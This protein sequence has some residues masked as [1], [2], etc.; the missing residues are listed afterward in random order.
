MSPTSKSLADTSLLNGVGGNNQLSRGLSKHLTSPSSTDGNTSSHMSSSHS[1]SEQNQQAQITRQTCSTE[2]QS[3]SSTTGSNSDHASL[4]SPS[5]SVDASESSQSATETPGESSNNKKN[6]SEEK[7]REKRKTSSSGGK[8]VVI[9]SGEKDDEDD[10]D[11]VEKAGEE[12][13]EEI[14]EGTEKVEG[15][16][17]RKEQ[18]QERKESSDDGTEQQKNTVSQT[19]P[20][21]NGCKKRK[22]YQPQQTTKV[23]NGSVEEDEELLDDDDL[24]EDDVDQD[25]DLDLSMNDASLDGDEDDDVASDLSVKKSSTAKESRATGTSASASDRLSLF[26]LRKRYMEQ[27]QQRPTQRPVNLSSSN[28]DDEVLDLE[29][30]KSPASH[31]GSGGESPSYF[32]RNRR[33]TNAS[34]KD[35]Q[36]PSLVIESLA[37]L[38][39]ELLENVVKTIEMT[40]EVAKRNALSGQVK[41]SHGRDSPKE[42]TLLAQMLESKTPHRGLLTTSNGTFRG[43]L[44]NLA[45]GKQSTPNSYEPLT[46]ESATVPKTLPPP[47]GPFGKVPFPHSHPFQGQG[48]SSNFST[49]SLVNREQTSPSR[50]PSPDD[51]ALSLVMGSRH[52]GNKRHKVTD[53]RITPRTVSRLLGSDPSFLNFF[54]RDVTTSPNGSSTPSVPPPLVPVSLPTS[55]A[56]PNPSLHHGVESLFSGGPAFPFSDAAS[57]LALFHG[58]QGGHPGLHHRDTPLGGNNSSPS[59]QGNG[60]PDDREE[61]DLRD[62]PNRESIHHHP[63]VD[64][65]AAHHQ[66]TMAREAA[67]E[68]AVAAAQQQQQSLHQ[69]QGGVAF[70]HHH[71]HSQQQAAMALAAAHHLSMLAAANRASPDSLHGYGNS[72]FSKMGSDNGADAGSEDASINESSLYDPNMPLTR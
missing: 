11:V 13:N 66:L 21:V 70:P 15:K 28:G 39:A 43:E 55:V 12:E 24:P 63:R 38:K 41:R 32:E 71:P 30:Q 54:G 19:Q 67:R 3:S 62:T 9:P 42:L 44:K 18:E 33:N 64:S 53:T 45:S 2:S 35:L 22:L 59:K 57:R 17:S 7:N 49:S 58:S 29:M 8:D 48:I 61:R 72:L 46:A 10:E 16:D 31:A 34:A 50:S 25:D 26:A 20:A 27:Q 37:A 1:P 40:F 23:L 52:R 60:N 68:R 14:E 56:V 47:P 65:A 5:S 36:M 69:Q 4:A 51:E 6:V